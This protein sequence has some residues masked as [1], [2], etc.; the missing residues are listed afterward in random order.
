MSDSETTYMDTNNVVTE[1]F[2]DKFVENCEDNFEI[3]YSN[4]LARALLRDNDDENDINWDECDSSSSQVHSTTQ[5][6]QK[7]HLHRHHLLHV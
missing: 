2:T 4:A 1:N 7:L 6:K 5:C 3:T